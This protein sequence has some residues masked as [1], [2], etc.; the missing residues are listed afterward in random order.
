MRLGQL[1]R[2]LSVSPTDIMKFLESNAIPAAEGSNMRL[3]DDHMRLILGRFDPA[4]VI[5]VAAEQADEAETV[6]SEPAAGVVTDVAPEVEVVEAAAPVVAE[7]A[8]PEPEFA[9]AG[10]VAQNLEDVVAG[11]PVQVSSES[12]TAAELPDV[13]K[14]PKVSLAGLK[15]LGK[16][17][18]PEPKKK[19]AAAPENTT[20]GA[21]GEP[22][23]PAVVPQQPQERRPRRERDGRD[24]DRRDGKDADGQRS[25]RGDNRRGD[26]PRKNPV[27]L[28]REREA[29]EAQLK[30]EAQ[31]KAEKERRTQHYHNRV[32][33]VPTK[34]ARL[35]REQTE[36]ITDDHTS[37]PKTWIGKFWKWFRS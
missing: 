6:V 34:P 17:E 11:E 32:K 29:Y 19:E 15:V 18:L 8:E 5:V 2:K 4:G 21:P 20:A 35:I 27:A 13:I 22:E 10:P 26:K 30:R 25:R 3:T 36:E 9:D 31:A 1:A 37:T 12:E 23:S 7:A 33:S 16:I 24:G 14:A 28:Q